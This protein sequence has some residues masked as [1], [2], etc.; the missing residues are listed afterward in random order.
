[1]I[2]RHELVLLHLLGHF[3]ERDRM[4]VPAVDSDVELFQG[5][6]PREAA[7]GMAM[8]VP[9]SPVAAVPRLKRVVAEDDLLLPHLDLFVRDDL[10]EAVVVRPLLLHEPIVIAMDQMD[11]TVQAPDVVHH[12]LRTT[13][14]GKVSDM[15]DR[16]ARLDLPVPVLDQGVIHLLDRLER[17]LAVLDD[18]GMTEVVVRGKI[19]V[20]Q[21]ILWALCPPSEV[22]GAPGGSRT[23]ILRLRGGSSTVELPRQIFLVVHLD[24]LPLATLRDTKRDAIPAVIHRLERSPLWI[25]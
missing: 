2:D 8:K 10:G 17:P 18:V 14:E 4:V 6:V 20:A 24:A 22:L 21:F 19:K 16:V 11:L 1:M 23:H 13:D 9:R 7:M 15:V 25:S 12:L 3:L 5:E